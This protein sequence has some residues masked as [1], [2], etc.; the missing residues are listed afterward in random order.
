MRIARLSNRLHGLPAWAAAMGVALAAAMPAGANEFAVAPQCRVPEYLIDDMASFPN[1]ARHVAD[2]RRLT[3][4]AIGAAST[5]GTAASSPAKAW[6]ARFAEYLGTRLSS[7]DVR[8]FN[9]GQR[10]QTARMAVDRLK[11]DV[12]ALKP[13]LIVWETGTV[14]AVRTTDPAEFADVVMEGVD[15]MTHLGADVI[16]IDPQYARATARLINFQP[17]LDA[18]RQAAGLPDVNLFPRHEIM[19]YW[20]DS[21]RVTPLTREEMTRGN[22][23]LYDCIAQLLADVVDRGLRQGAHAQRR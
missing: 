18:L 7:I 23:E 5:Q 10:G 19:R 11:Q 14:E 17:Y 8:V 20:A 2:E 12:A 21:G 22:D 15:A 4:V 13:D 6:P 9:L 3:V 16:L 1:A